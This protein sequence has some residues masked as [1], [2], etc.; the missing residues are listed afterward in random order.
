[1]PIIDI[2]YVQQ[3]SLDQIKENGYKLKRQDEDDIP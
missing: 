2:D 3:T 1:M